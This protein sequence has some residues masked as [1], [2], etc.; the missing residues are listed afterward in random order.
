LQAVSTDH[1]PFCMKNEKQLGKDDFSKIPNGAPGIET[2][3]SLV[4]DGGV[5][6]N[7]L[8][9]NRYVEITSTSPA[10][11][12]GLFPRKG[13]IAVGSDADIVVW[14]PKG[15]ITWSAKTHH[16]NV[17]YNPYEGRTCQG[18]PSIVLSRGEVIVE[19]GSCKAKPGRG[20]Y[21]KRQAR[22]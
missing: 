3:M 14:D 8:T 19:Q 7:Q 9:M 18:A 4:Y 22:S 17:D 5:L 15:S 12:F 2:R 16:M 21:L 10:K 13:T 20:Q 6:K 11:I 1:C